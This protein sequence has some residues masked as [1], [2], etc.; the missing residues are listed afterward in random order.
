[1]KGKEVVEQEMMKG[2]DIYETE[3]TLED[4]LNYLLEDLELPEMDKK[5]F[6][7]F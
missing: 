2:E 1:M 5:N 3:I 4:A 6:Q 7:K